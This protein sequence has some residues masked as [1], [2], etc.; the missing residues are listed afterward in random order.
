M[1]IGKWFLCGGTLSFENDV[2]IDIIQSAKTF[3]G[4]IE[5]EVKLFKVCKRLQFGIQISSK[6]GGSLIGRSVEFVTHNS[7]TAR[8]V[9]LPHFMNSK[10]LNSTGGS[11]TK[12]GEMK[13]IYD[14]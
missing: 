9:F 3:A 10:Y 14:V 4:C 1:Y 13:C 6:E 2:D 7:G 11:T 12:E 8:F 5:L